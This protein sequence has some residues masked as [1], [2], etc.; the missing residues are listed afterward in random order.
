MILRTSAPLSEIANTASRS[1]DTS[2]Y[3]F[4]LQRE[5]GSA[6][7]ECSPGNLVASL[8]PSVSQVVD[9]I[10]LEVPSVDFDFYVT[11]QSW[12]KAFRLGMTSILH[13]RVN[14]SANASL[15][16]AVGKILSAHQLYLQRPAFLPPGQI[17]QNPHH[18]K[19]PGIEPRKLEEEH[20]AGAQPES[21]STAEAAAQEELNN[22]DLENEFAVVFGSLMLWDK[23]VIY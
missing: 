5:D 3:H 6:C 2:N 12:S 1:F 9:Q 11:R 7:L 23:V 22:D 10:L 19:F 14:V 20:K 8:D 21:G 15:V 17:Y 13:A 18:F 16:M 4:H